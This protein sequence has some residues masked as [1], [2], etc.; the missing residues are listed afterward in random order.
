MTNQLDKQL[1]QQLAQQQEWPLAPELETS[2]WLNTPSPISLAQLRGK[3]VVIHAFQ[4]LCPG[5]VSHGIPQASAIHQHYQHDDVQVIG[6]HS[7]FEHHQVMNLAALT[8]FIEEYR[9]TF[10]IAIDS[11]S[12][13]GAIPKTMASYQMQGTPTLLVIDKQG[14][15]RVNAFGRPSD[16]QVGDIIGRLLAEDS[17]PPAHTLRENHVSGNQAKGLEKEKCNDHGC[18]L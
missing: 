5:C 3:V 7:V 12:A 16:L 18:S 17:Q 10:P 9:L 2:T 6:L 13:S 4:M 15:L 14:R 11:P 1:T 8:A